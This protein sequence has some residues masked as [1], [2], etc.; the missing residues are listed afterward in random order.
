M[1]VLGIVGSPRK[2]G[3]T[4]ILVKEALD[5][6]RNLGAEIEIINISDLNITPCDGCESCDT[7]GKCKIED[8]MQ[9]IYIKLLQSDGIILGSPVY[10]WGVTAQIKAVIDRTF[11]FR[12][13]RQLRNKVGGAIVV[14]RYS[15]ASS[16]FSAFL[17]F[18][19]LQRMIPATAIGPRTEE[20]LARERG[21]GV[22]AYADKRGEVK[23]DKPAIARAHSLGKAI[24][25]TIQILN[26]Q[27]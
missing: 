24:V 27:Q 23:K 3:N 18:F 2:N 12:K 9:D 20:E 21:G 1:K 4:E 16:A 15:G 13:D 5:S 17:D 10:Y 6:A 26:S 25:E 7:T 8:D 19:S 22:I 14:A 11:L